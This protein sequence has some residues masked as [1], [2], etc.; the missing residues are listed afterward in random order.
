MNSHRILKTCMVIIIPL[1]CA[2]FYT[3]LPRNWDALLSSRAYYFITVSEH[4]STVNEID[5]TV[6][7][8]RDL[9]FTPLLHRF[10]FFLSRL[11]E[12]YSLII[13][14]ILC[15]AI[16]I[17]LFAYIRLQTGDGVLIAALLSF[18]FG[19]SNSHMTYAGI[20]GSIE[21]AGLLVMITISFWILW[22]GSCNPLSMVFLLIS[23]AAL[24]LQSP[25]TL[26][27]FSFGYMISE[28]IHMGTWR[29]LFP[30]L[31]I[32]ILTI[33]IAVGVRAQYLSVAGGETSHVEFLK[34]SFEYILSQG[35]ISRLVSWNH[36]VTVLLNTSVTAIIG[37]PV[38]SF[39]DAPV[40]AAYCAPM[41]ILKGYTMHTPALLALAPFVY[42]FLMSIARG[43]YFGRFGVLLLTYM[44]AHG[45]FF[46]FFD[47]RY[48]IP[49]SPQIIGPFL[50]IFGDSLE[51]IERYKKVPLLILFVLLT[52]VANTMIHIKLAY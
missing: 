38:Q 17:G 19:L 52:C 15:A 46:I 37:V 8:D 33:L 47:P 10:P 31:G 9:L 42:L 32:S 29:G 27:L 50:L 14:G 26:I 16:S 49:Y 25:I 3:F 23:M 12:N 20:P 40:C 13:P 35:D 7:R 22:V 5:F 6:N 51:G 21:P 39:S 41:D 24:G 18:L 34:R 1:I 48:S 2:V 44:V 28:W 45:L 30:A 43:G 11:P 36:I 4:V